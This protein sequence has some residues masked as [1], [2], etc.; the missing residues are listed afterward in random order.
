MKNIA[1]ALD[2]NFLKPEGDVPSRWNSTYLM[3]R[4]LEEIRTVTDVLVNKRSNLAA[5]YLQQN[6][7]TLIRV[8]IQIFCSNQ[9][10]NVLTCKV[11]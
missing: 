10:K 5:D 3:L 8:R 11:T 7:W 6:D 9:A 4:R 1:S 2:M